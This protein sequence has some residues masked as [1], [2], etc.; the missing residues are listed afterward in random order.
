M[1]GGAK[2]KQDTTQ[3]LVPGLRVASKLKTAETL[4]ITLYI[5]DRQRCSIFIF[6]P[7]RLEKS[8]FRFDYEDFDQH[9]AVASVVGEQKKAQAAWNVFS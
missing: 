6:S 8:Q 9:R 2:H 1:F 3:T 5:V 4:P 7:D